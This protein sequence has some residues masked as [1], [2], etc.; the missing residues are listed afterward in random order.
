MEHGFFMEQG[1]FI[2]SFM[3]PFMEQGFIF[4][5]QGLAAQGFFFEQGFC[6]MEQGFCFMAHGL[7][8]QGFFFIAHGLDDLA[9]CLPMAMDG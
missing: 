6:F 8:A 4:I 5:E 2:W 1:F 7:A 9:G 3:L